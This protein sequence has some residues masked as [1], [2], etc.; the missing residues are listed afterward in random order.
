MVT[1]FAVEATVI[2]PAPPVVRSPAAL[3]VT[4]VAPVKDKSPDVEVKTLLTINAPAE[5]KVM[6]PDPSAV[7]AEET[8]KSPE[9]VPT[10]IFP[11]EEVELDTDNHALL[12]VNF[13]LD[14]LKEVVKAVNEID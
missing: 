12:I 11:F 8:V 7:I 6:F 14:Q 2:V 3:C 4:P 5:F 13:E 10:S 9:T 1:S